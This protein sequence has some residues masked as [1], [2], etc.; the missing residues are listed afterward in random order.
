MVL[1]GLTCASCMV[2]VVARWIGM[3]GLSRGQN[4]DVKVNASYCGHR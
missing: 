1:N 2:Q 3:F 4:A